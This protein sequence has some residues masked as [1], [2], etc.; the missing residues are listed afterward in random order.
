[1]GY[2]FIYK[3]TVAHQEI[4]GKKPSIKLHYNVGTVS[5]CQPR[6]HGSQSVI[7]FSVTLDIIHVAWCVL[8]MTRLSIS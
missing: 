3:H 2:I 5:V 8:L 7:P 6:E 1:M 4:G